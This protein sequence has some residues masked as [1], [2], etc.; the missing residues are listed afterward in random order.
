[1]HARRTF[2]IGDLHLDHKNI[3][4]YCNRPFSSVAEMNRTIVDNWDRMVGEGDTIYFL[5]D[6]CYGRGSKGIDYWIKRL[7]G[8]IVF[9]RGYHD[10]PTNGIQFHGSMILNHDG[11]KF[12]LI[13]N[14]R[15]A[16]IEWDGWVVHGHVHNNRPFMDRKKKL[17]NVSAE[18]LNYRPISLENLMDMIGR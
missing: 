10:R 2:F 13:H 18:V 17:I 4:R 15:D 14:P 5:G 6:M 1:M 9:I 3:I 11:E 7:N 16:P 8:E 12:L